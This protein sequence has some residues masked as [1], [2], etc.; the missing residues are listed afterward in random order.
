MIPAGQLL[1]GLYLFSQGRR[2][3][4][5]QSLAAQEN[6]MKSSLNIVQ[7]GRLLGCENCWC[8]NAL[9][10]PDPFGDEQARIAS[11]CI[12]DMALMS[13]HTKFSCCIEW[14][15]VMLHNCAFWAAT[16]WSTNKILR[17]NIF[18][19]P[20]KFGKFLLFCYWLRVLDSTDHFIIFSPR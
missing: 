8:E 19:H 5:I 20:D 6:D 14:F 9:W 15:C 16:F 3:L 11:K 10:T 18:C 2:H 12:H 13:Y 7:I 4:Y 1:A 17:P